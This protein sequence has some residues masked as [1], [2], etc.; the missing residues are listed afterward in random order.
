MIASLPMYDWPEIRNHI[1]QFWQKMATALLPMCELTPMTLSRTDIHEQWQRDDL[2]LSQTCIYPLV[3]ELPSST[4][5]V[6][7]PTYDVEW[8]LH[9]QYASV[10]LIGKTD[11]R[12]TLSSFN[13]STLAYNSINSQ[14]GFNALKSLLTEEQLINR[15]TAVFFS[16]SVQTHSHRMS[17]EAVATGAADICA[18]DPV[19][20]ALSQRYDNASKKVR[21]LRSTAFEPALPLITSAD[22]IPAVLTESQ[23]QGI[24]MDAFEM[25]IDGDAKNQ[26]LL[27]GITF[28]PKSEYLK[29]PISKLDMITQ[30]NTN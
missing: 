16:K 23:W 14:S 9:G 17:I 29:L 2:L 15:E 18:V 20:W 25:C 28:I 5:V 3:T 26:L 24:V 27:N 10:V 21:I 11:G 13:G 7:T 30:P 19:S 4:V 8:S 1:D 12:N 6:G 22:A